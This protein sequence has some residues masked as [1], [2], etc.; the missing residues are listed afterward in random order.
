MTIWTNNIASIQ[1]KFKWMQSRLGRLMQRGDWRDQRLKQDI[2]AAI[3]VLYVY[4]RHQRY[5]LKHSTR[6]GCNVVGGGYKA[7]DTSDE[8]T[9]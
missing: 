4:A 1:E 9:R 7:P 3:E 2:G 8:A 5:S 6:E